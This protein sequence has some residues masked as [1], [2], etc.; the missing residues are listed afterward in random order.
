V[1][2][3]TAPGRVGV[4]LVLSDA[5]ILVQK[6]P[7][8]SNWFRL[9]PDS[10]GHYAGGI[11]TSNAGLN[12]PEIRQFFASD[13]LPD[14]R[15]LVAGGEYGALGTGLTAE[16][17]DPV[18][19]HWLPVPVP[20]GLLQTNLLAGNGYNGGFAD[21]PSIVLADG[22]VL[23]AANYPQIP[24]TT[25]IY[26]PRA[27]SWSTVPPYL[28]TN[29]N[30]VTFVKLPDDSI[31]TIDNQS[32]TTERYIP[33]LGVW[34]QDQNIPVAM[35]SGNA[36]IGGTVL[37]PNGKAFFL[38]GTGSTLLYTPSG[39]TNQGT[40]A[41]GATIPGGLVARDA[42]MAMMPNGNV[43]CC[44]SPQTGDS[45]ISFYEYNPNNNTFTAV[46]SPTGPGVYAGGDIT[47]QTAML[48]LPDG[49]IL[50][51]AA[52]D[53]NAYIYQPSGAPLAAWKPV[54]T[55]VVY[56][57]DG[58]LHITGTQ[59]NG[60]SQGA[61]FGDDNQM[62]SNYPL[63]RFTDSGGNV[64]YGRSHDWSSTGVQTGSRIVS[65]ECDLPSQ[66]F[67]GPGAYTMQVVANGIASDPVSFPGPV[68][69]DFNYAGLPKIGTYAN[70]Y[71]TLAQGTNAVPSGGTVI[72]K[73]GLSHETMAISKPMVI[74]SYG[75]TAI[76][77]Q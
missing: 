34:I 31:L 51:T 10:Q 74:T 30:E 27:N 68:W 6:G 57:A 48:V 47:D 14:G 64:Y 67:N 33:S 59:L 71:N 65:T 36:E 12:M 42:P 4:A 61:S 73:P 13:V 22:T 24:K 63:V 21:A 9:S 75:G 26:N 43:L 35:Y 62:D 25:L 11:W 60:L 77:G 32:L 76:V 5:S 66:V 44:F 17:Y 20:V 1:T 39:N 53:R 2:N 40:W 46:N 3:T 23:I 69:V 58:T 29:L 41:L 15:V 52:H 7:G 37:L 8:D 49:N 28:G 45:P 56:N 38:G 18:A 16:I 50:F 72:L 55:S 54:I 19:N 70:P